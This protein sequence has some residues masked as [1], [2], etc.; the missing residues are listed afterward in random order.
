MN[1]DTNDSKPLLIDRPL[2]HLY[3]PYTFYTRINIAIVIVAI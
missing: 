3:N 1:I 2:K